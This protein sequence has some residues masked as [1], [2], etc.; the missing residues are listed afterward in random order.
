MASQDG[1]RNTNSDELN[2]VAP[3]W[4]DSVLPTDSK[5]WSQSDV[6]LFKEYWSLL[7]LKCA[8]KSLD[9]LV[10]LVIR[11]KALGIKV[12]FPKEMSESQRFE[13]L[14]YAMKCFLATCLLGKAFCTASG[15]SENITFHTSSR[16][17][18]DSILAKLPGV[19]HQVGGEVTGKTRAESF[20]SY[21]ASQ[22][23]KK[24]VR[25]ELFFS[26]IK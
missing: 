3:S 7:R 6:Q 19:N 2:E 11:A 10:E 17:S 5:N 20:T 9:A 13:L 1:R 22:P 8:E 4:D 26:S 14:G 16:G 23:K 21:I 25:T 24:K 15:H 18:I 12:D